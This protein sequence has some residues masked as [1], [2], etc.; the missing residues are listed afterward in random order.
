MFGANS[1]EAF[2]NERERD[3]PLQPGG[4]AWIVVAVV[5]KLPLEDYVEEHGGDIHI[6]HPVDKRV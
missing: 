1:L 4:E 3:F 6:E 5:R 2:A